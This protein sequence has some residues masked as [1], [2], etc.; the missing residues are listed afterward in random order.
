M[1]RSDGSGTT[2]IFTDYLSKV[3]P[4]WKQKVGSETAVAWPEGVGGK[5][6]EGVAAY[7]Q[8]IKGAIGYVEYAYA[9][10]NK[11]SVRAGAE[12]G[13]PVSAARQRRV[14][15]RRGQRGLEEAPRLL[16]D[17]HGPAGQD[18]VADR[19]HELHPHARRR[20]TKPQ[21]AAEVLKFFDWSFKNGDKMAEDLDYVPLPESLVAQIESSWKCRSRTP[22]EN[23]SGTDPGRRVRRGRE[24]PCC[25]RADGRVIDDA[26]V[27]LRSYHAFAGTAALPTVMPR[28]AVR[29]VH[30]PMSP[31]RRRRSGSW[32]DRVFERTTLFFALFV[33]ALLAGILVALGAAWRRAA[34]VRGR[35]LLH[36]RLEPG[37]EHFGGLAP[38]YGTL[39]TSMIA[40]A[41][42]VPVS[43]GIAIFLTEMC[44]PAL[45]R[46][47]GTAVELLA[48]VPSI[49]YGMW[50]LFIFAPLFGDH[51]QPL[52]MRTLGRIPDRRAVPGSA[53]RDRHPHVRASSSR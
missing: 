31:V 29:D 49:I 24:T 11:M 23:P 15:G 43:F 45:K 20:R 42:G 47:L 9:K 19:R 16:P 10:Q 34:E 50:G 26:A 52:L 22:P 30:E 6:N 41:I 2:F 13:R 7:V 5:G 3:S 4:E 28:L 25:P 46:P 35:L 17:P 32:G 27:F 12:Q 44:P 39:V 40:L 37:D 53:K 48:A 33:L 1:R 51:V 14:P 21:N 38:I 8:R 18:V 36:Q